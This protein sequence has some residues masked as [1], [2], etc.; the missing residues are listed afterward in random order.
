[1][2]YRK[3]FVCGILAVLCAALFC[4]RAQA[5][6]RASLQGTVTDAQGAVV[7]DAKVTLTSKETGTARVATTNA[8]GV[9]SINGLPPGAYSLTVTRDGFKKKVLDS[10]AIAAEVSQA[11]DVQLDVGQVSETVT[12]TG[13]AASL[14]DTETANIAGS[15]TDRELQSLPSSGRDPFQLLR[16]APGAFGEGARENFADNAGPGTTNPGS[17]IFQTENQ[18]QVSANGQRVNSNSYQ[19]DGVSVNSQAWGGAAVVTPNEESI[20]EVKVSTN[21]YSAEHGRGAGAQIE[22]VSKNGTNQFHGSAFFKADRPGLNAYNRWNGPFSSPARQNDRFNQFGGSVGGPIIRNKLFAFF[23]YETQR[24]HSTNTGND[25]YETPWFVANAAPAGSIA[26]KY[27]TFPGIGVA[28]NKVN[29]VSCT[30][31]GLVEGTN[32]HAIAGQGLDLGRPLD[33]ELFPLGTR[34]PSWHMGGEDNSQP[35]LGGD[36]TGDPSNLD[37]NADF[38]NVQTVSPSRSTAVQYNGRID[39]NVTSKDLVA[40][41]IYW[42]PVEGHFLNG[43]ARPMNNYSNIR[44]NYSWAVIWQ[45]TISSTWLNEAR[46]NSAGWHWNEIDSNPQE[47][48]G[49]LRDTLDPQTGSLPQRF[50]LWGPPGPSVFNQKFYNGRDVLTKVQ[51]SHTLKF[52]ADIYRENF[53]DRAP[54]DAIPTYNFRNLWDFANDAP[55]SE[56]Y[57]WG[58]G[59]NF[60][61][62]DGHPTDVNK[63]I[64]DNILAFFVQDDWK[65]K[66]NLTVNLGL[67][68]EYYSALVDANSNIANPVFGSGNNLL[69]DLRVKVGGSLYSPSKHNFGPQLGFAWSPRFVADDKLVLR[70]G[71]GIGFD[72]VER[73]PILDVRSNYPLLANIFF[74]DPSTIVYQTADDLHQFGGWPANPNAISTPD[75]NNLPQSGSPINLTAVNQNLATPRSYH[76]SVDGQYNLGRNWVASVGYTGSQTRNYS[77]SIPMNIVSLPGAALNPRVQ[78]LTQRTNDATASSNALLTRLQHRFSTSFM[79]DTQYRLAKITDQAP[80]GY[81]VGEY[82]YAARFAE[83]PANYDARHSFKLIAGY[84]PVLFHGENSWMEKVLGG[85]SIDGIL[86]YHSGFPW[87][88]KYGGSV[89]GCNLIYQGSG[90]CDVRPASYLGGAGSDYGNDTFKKQNGNFPN[91]GEAYFTPPSVTQ[92]PSFSDV[93]NGIED[94][95]P[96]PPVPGVGR[97]SFRGPRYFSTDM[98]L[99]KAFGLPAMPVLGEGAKFEFRADF[100]NLFNQ[101]NLRNVNNTIT[102]T[103]FGQAQNAYAGRT[104]ELQLKFSF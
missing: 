76:Y 31:V 21:S 9:Y 89:T 80:T 98:T 59:T 4:T 19:I 49:L 30:D 81:Y 55:S 25:W 52:G 18:A 78:S 37:G 64:R 23:S 45:R 22:V 75:D 29:D 101:L 97:N 36:G 6:Y 17:S 91:G 12:V 46:F 69:T 1:M 51:H 15:I 48:W 73:A 34:D 27:M 28:F 82:P 74:P 61:P 14:I 44:T 35:G 32:C 83:G 70:G 68:W 5:Q 84:S 26:E 40:F 2:N 79:I 92:G 42:V 54:W 50:D 24:N 33:T 90:Y 88:P 87:S 71:F 47:P 13:E 39:Y 60:N 43:P 93:A 10:L 66:P 100:F 11:A 85:W 96:A 77:R 8:A 57:P 3:L 58:S 7:P 72:Q 62:Q 94:P 38:F 63:E 104:V 41:S 86:S 56:G 65:V 16:L 67:R 102:D 20:K 53:N 95:G 99:R 103:H